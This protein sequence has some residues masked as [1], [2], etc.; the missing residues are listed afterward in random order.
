[1]FICK[2][3]VGT[4]LKKLFEFFARNV[5]AYIG[6]FF[7]F[8]LA[9]CFSFFEYFVY[10][11]KCE[12]KI[13]SKNAKKVYQNCF[14][15]YLS[16]SISAAFARCLIFSRLFGVLFFDSKEIPISVCHCIPQELHCFFFVALGVF[17]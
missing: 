6:N 1:M 3:L 9:F 2:R 8:A 7:E 14:P 13:M 17:H 4:N 16:L 5:L 12:I 11:H 15:K 10:F